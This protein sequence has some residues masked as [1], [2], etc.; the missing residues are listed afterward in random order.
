VAVTTAAT[1]RFP[2]I[3]VHVGGH[4]RAAARRAGRLG[5]G[6]QP[7]GFAGE[8][9]TELLALMHE[10]ARESGRDPDTLELTLG[11]LV[12]RVDA[13]RAARLGELGAARLVLATSA[14]RDLREAMDELSACAERLRL[15]GAA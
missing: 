13:D 2:K 5:D 1:T 10:A 7:L 11:H 9:L 6:L 3:P 4:T 12:S 14:T 15:G 8:Q